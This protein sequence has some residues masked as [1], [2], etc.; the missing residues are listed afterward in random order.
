MS[1]E[2]ASVLG[3]CMRVAVL[4]GTAKGGAS[5]KVT[6]AAKT[7]TA[8]TGIIRNGRNVN[9]AWYAGFF[10][11]ENPRYVCVV[12][13]EDGSSGGASAGPVFREIAEKL[14]RIGNQK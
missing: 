4:E 3:A 10:P 14:I 8:E 9:Q 5:D 7:G 2:T 13:C 12:L 11:Y 6:S 1:R